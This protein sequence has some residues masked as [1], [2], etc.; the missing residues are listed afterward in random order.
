MRQD[1]PRSIGFW[2]GCGIMVGIIIGSGIFRTPT[3]IAREMGDSRLILLLWL[4]GGVLSLAGALT[5]AELG[6]MFPRS[7]GIYAYMYEGLGGTVAFV[8]GWTYML[9]GKPLAASAITMVFAEHFDKLFGLQW[10]VRAITCVVLILLTAV[11]TVR[12]RLG[13]GIAIVLTTLKALALAAIIV[14]GLTLARGSTANFAPVASSKSFL[15]AL[16]P[17]LAAVLWTYD[18]WADVT[19]VAGEIREPDRL[20]PRILV[21]G[22]GACIALFVAVNAV[23]I[24]MVPLP[25]MRG[26]PTVAPLVMEKLC[27]PV[28]ATVVTL[29]V[30]I[31]TL[32]ASHGSIITG[33]RVTFAQARDGLLFRVL[34]RIHH[35]YQTPHIALWCQAILSCVAVCFLKHFER[36]TGGFVFTMW[37]FYAAAAV[38]MIVLRIRRPE[39]NRPCRCWGY[40]VVPV[41]FIAA[42]LLITVLAIKASPVETLC[43]LGILVTGAPAYYLW[44]RWVPAENAAPAGLC[45]G[46]GYNLYGLRDQR[47][48]ECGRPFTFEEVGT[49][50]VSPGFAIA[51]HETKGMPGSGEPMDE[52]N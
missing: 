41:A 47:C 32:G 12:V 26:E 13:A 11:N 23:Y 18:G 7:G 51:A 31:S 34:G 15:S 5:Y 24:Y 1:L 49:M 22:T 44:R 19:S 43:W 9:L 35:R 48:P 2:G 45:P 50:P 27:G 25:Q 10:D 17:V 52:R 21:V 36:L 38:S 29:M 46:C 14:L 3:S 42:S 16:A 8:F 30:M 33:A 37:I 4:L 28:G 40:P 20:L 39:L 6:T